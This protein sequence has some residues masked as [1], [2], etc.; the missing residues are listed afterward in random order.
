M[1]RYV[2]LAKTHIQHFFAKVSL[3]PLIG[4]RVSGVKVSVLDISESV[5]FFGMNFGAGFDVKLFKTVFFNVESKYMLSFRNE[6]ALHGF[7][8]SA[9]LIFRF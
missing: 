1:T 2:G 8:T 6:R 5:A 9:G 3:Y 7:T 4:L